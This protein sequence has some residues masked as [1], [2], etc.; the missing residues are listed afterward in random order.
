MDYEKRCDVCQFKY[1]ESCEEPDYFCMFGLEYCK[2][3]ELEKKKI[4]RLKNQLECVCDEIQV[5]K[6]NNTLTEMKEKILEFEKNR[7]NEEM[8]KYLEALMKKGKTFYE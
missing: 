4:K 1:C 5:A 6:E 3:T 7:I 8:G 2:L